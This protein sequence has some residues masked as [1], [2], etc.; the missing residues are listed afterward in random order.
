M[1]NE[2]KTWIYFTA[3]SLESDFG[4]IHRQPGDYLDTCCLTLEYRSCLQGC[5]LLVR[6]YHAKDQMFNYA[7]H[8]QN[9][10]DRNTLDRFLQNYD[11]MLSNKNKRLDKDV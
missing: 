6:L 1:V 8:L 9:A 3:S 2:Q 7:E 4:S 10:G 11:K 5:K